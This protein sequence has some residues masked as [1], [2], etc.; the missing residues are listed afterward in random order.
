MVKIQIQYYLQCFLS[1][2][3]LTCLF[4]LLTECK[5]ITGAGVISQFVTACCLPV[6][7]I[8]KYQP[9]LRAASKPYV[10][11]SVAHLCDSCFNKLICSCVIPSLTKLFVVSRR[12]KKKMMIPQFHGG[13]RA[14]SET[15]ALKTGGFKMSPP[16]FLATG[17][18]RHFLCCL[19]CL[20][21]P[22]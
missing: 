14:A 17:F 2:R 10:V 9:R 21:L 12:K 11:A 8:W 20:Q 19:S 13:K 3:S 6:T 22:G 15:R 4:S 7:G 18:S 5:E 1:L 16:T